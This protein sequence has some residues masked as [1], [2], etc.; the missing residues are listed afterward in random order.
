MENHCK[1][2]TADLAAT[3]GRYE[4]MFNEAFPKIVDELVTEDEKNPEIRYLF[5][6]ISPLLSNDAFIMIS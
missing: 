2:P 4:Q 1:T 5:V 3:L 6:P